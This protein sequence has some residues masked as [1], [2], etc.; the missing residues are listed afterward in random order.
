MAGASAYPRTIDFDRFAEICK[1]VGALFMVDMAHI[2][3]LVAGDQHPSPVPWAD[4]ATSTTH[5]TLRGPRSGFV[6][7]KKEWA[8][9]VNQAVFPGMQGGPLMHVIAAKAIGFDEALQPAFRSY[10]AQIV[11]N[12]RT[13]AH[14]LTARQFRLVSGGTDNHLTAGGRGVARPVRQDGGKRAWTPP[15]S[16]ST[17]TAFP[18]TP[19]RRSTRRASASARRP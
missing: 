9:K 10:S 4:F 12:A 5:K 6:L 16:R 13:L 18:S 2:A 7:C 3:G 1:E 8:A 15:A 14:E 17:A 19:G 11:A